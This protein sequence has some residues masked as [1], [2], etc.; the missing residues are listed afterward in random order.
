MTYL[1]IFVLFMGIG[2]NERY[3]WALVL[4]GGAMVCVGALQ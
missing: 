2:S 1:G 3:S 4:A